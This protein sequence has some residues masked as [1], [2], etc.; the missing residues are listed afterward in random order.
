VCQNL[1]TSHWNP[2]WSILPLGRLGCW[3]SLAFCKVRPPSV[4]TCIFCVG[5]LLGVQVV[6]TMSAPVEYMALTA[7]FSVKNVSHGCIAH[8]GQLVCRGNVAI[9]LACEEPHVWWYPGLQ[10]C[11]LAG[12]RCWPCVLLDIL[13]IGTIK[14]LHILPDVSRSE[15]RAPRSP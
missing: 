14:T 11:R 1:G 10:S 2:A 4:A 13:H 3:T 9:P 15:W 5:Y 12:P 6:C 8:A 7:Q